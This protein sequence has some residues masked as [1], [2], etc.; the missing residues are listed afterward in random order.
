[1]LVAA[2]LFVHIG[3]K[4]RGWKT[5]VIDNIWTTIL[6]ICVFLVKIFFKNNLHYR[7]VDVWILSGISWSPHCLLHYATHQQSNVLRINS[8]SQKTS[9]RIK[10]RFSF[11]SPNFH[12]FSNAILFKMCVKNASW[13]HRAF[14][15]PEKGSKCD[16]MFNALTHPE[17]ENVFS[18]GIFMFM[19][20]SWFTVSIYCTECTGAVGV[21]IDHLSKVLWLYVKPTSPLYPVTL[22]AF[23]SVHCVVKY[24]LPQCSEAWPPVFS[25]PLQKPLKAPNCLPEV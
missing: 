7:T 4:N 2:I 16:V 15:N 22:S 10:V 20:D 11:F 12:K 19:T 5:S 9:L 17:A 24:R 8:D 6:F 21:N 23:Q 13:K 18:R 25:S 3:C 14:Q 1:M